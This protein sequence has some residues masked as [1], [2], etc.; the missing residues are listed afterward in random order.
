VHAVPSLRV[1][2]L[3]QP[4]FCNFLL[5]GIIV[6]RVCVLVHPRFEMREDRSCWHNSTHA[7]L[8]HASPVLMRNRDIII[9]LIQILGFFYWVL[10][11][12]LGGPARVGSIGVPWYTAST[13]KRLSGKKKGKKNRGMVERRS[14]KQLSASL[15]KRVV[16]VI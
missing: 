5:A 15:H 9:N 10:R 1:R 3:L 13:K 4:S 8:R 6:L 7:L 11:T 2:V 12:V 14:T 16:A